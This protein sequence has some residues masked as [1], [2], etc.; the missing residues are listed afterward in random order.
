MGEENI[1]PNQLTC[2][3]DLFFNGFLFPI[4]LKF[5]IKTGIVDSFKT[6]G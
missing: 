1:S 3:E 4:I 2:E 5:V 6:S